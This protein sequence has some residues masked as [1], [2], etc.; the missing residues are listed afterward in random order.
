MSHLRSIEGGGEDAERF[1]GVES[2]I[3][4]FV[5][6]VAEGISEGAKERDIA[7]V[8]GFLHDLE[9][10]TRSPRELVGRDSDEN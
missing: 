9:F 5:I 2:I 8:K 4:D 10:G 6:P 1:E 7:K 3:E